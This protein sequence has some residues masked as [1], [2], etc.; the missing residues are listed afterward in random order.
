MRKTPFILVRLLWGILVCGVVVWS[1]A[2][3]AE[4]KS[5]T[6]EAPRTVVPMAHLAFDLREALATT[7]SER[8]YLA[9]RVEQVTNQRWL[10]IAYGFLMSLVAGW[11]GLILL[12]RPAVARPLVETSEAEGT[13][14][15]NEGTSVTVR[16]RKNATITIRNSA[17]Q[18]EEV[19][20][21]V[22]TRRLF[23]RSETRTQ[24]RSDQ[25]PR[26]TPTLEISPVVETDLRP[27]T[28]RTVCPTEVTPLASEIP[29]RRQITV[30]VEHHSDRLPQVEVA[31]KPGTAAVV[32]QGFSLL[33]VM[34]S[35]AILAT[36]MASVMAGMYTLH[37]TRT[38]ALEEGHARELSRRVVERIMSESIWSLNS[39]RV[40]E[41]WR[42]AYVTDVGA[43]PLTGTRLRDGFGQLPALNDV[44]VFVEY[45][46]RSALENAINA[47]QPLAFTVA[48]RQGGADRTM[49]I[50]VVVQW[51]SLGL[52]STAPP[53][54]HSQLFA[55]S[56]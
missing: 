29:N 27:S 7:T 12:K 54:I 22:E 41:L 56:E 33:E 5:T 15:P 30:R 34:I 38:M 13:L 49:A 45:Y 44:K 8:D 21:N 19:V 25:T 35:L 46:R 31:L 40:G 51:Q 14:E 4:A 39:G 6:V 10:L 3:A 1:S 43:D 52:E 32:R 17:T 48:N 2:P 18:R 36:V 9:L 11:L 47:Q 26:A 37:R 53:R 28:D 50:R 42:A 24:H 20:G 16:Q 23:A 55:R